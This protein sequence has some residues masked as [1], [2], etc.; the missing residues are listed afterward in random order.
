[1]LPLDWNSEK[2]LHCCVVMQNKDLY[3]YILFTHFLYLTSRR[4]PYLNVTGFRG[5]AWTHKKLVTQILPLCSMQTRV[6]AKGQA[7]LNYAKQRVFNMWVQFLYKSSRRN[8][9]SNVLISGGLLLAKA[10]VCIFV[11]AENFWTDYMYICWMCYFYYSS[12]GHICLVILYS[13]IL[14]V[15]GIVQW[16]LSG[17]DTMLK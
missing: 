13:V 16:I 9:I 10:V 5:I 11:Q 8:P 6:S 1:M 4:I 3:I 15:K 2:W 17:V 7:A 12:S 14:D